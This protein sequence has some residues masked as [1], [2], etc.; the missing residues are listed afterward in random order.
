MVNS[1]DSE[2][3]SEG[4][5][6]TPICPSCVALGYFFQLHNGD[7]KNI[8]LVRTEAIGEHMESIY[9]SASTLFFF[10][11]CFTLIILLY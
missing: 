11:F 5:V 6:L 10:F 3:D 9:N 8:S 4:Q 7:N 1:M 2:P